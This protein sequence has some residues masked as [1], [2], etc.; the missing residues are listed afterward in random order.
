MAEF[1][2]LVVNPPEK[3]DQVLE[4]WEGLGVTGVT[5]LESSGLGRAQRLRDD[6][7]LFPSLRN[8]F[9]SEEYHHRTIF[10]VVGEEVDLDSLFAATENIL[11][12]LDD[13]NTGIMITWPVSRVRGLAKKKSK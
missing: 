7:P 3:L 11:G 9:E 12:K 2:L 13:P 8:L 10:T 5:I 6:L 4:A 1:V